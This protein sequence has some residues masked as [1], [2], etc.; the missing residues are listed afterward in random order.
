MAT[1]LHALPALTLLVALVAAPAAS[2][3]LE[4]QRSFKYELRSVGAHAGEA[5]LSIGERTRVGE[6]WLRAVHLE[7]RTAGLLGKLYRAGADATTWIDDHWLPVRAH[8]NGVTKTGK[9]RVDATFEPKRIVSE[10]ERE[11]KGTKKSTAPLKARVTDS[12]SVFAWMI[13]QDLTPGTT[14][15]R[16]LFSGNRIYSLNIEVGEPERIMVPLGLRTAI[17]VKV[18][19][20]RGKKFK[21]SVTY[22]IGAED[23]VPYKLSFSYGAIGSVDAV[24]VAMRD[25]GT[26]T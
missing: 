6:R 3:A 1:R 9:R 26:S 13:N 23:R 17:P 24:L 18:E 11:G 19:A 14:Y 8:W 4:G 22:W 5:I 25:G 10:Y 7:A 16:Q 2:A 21:R 20:T 15:A 12:V